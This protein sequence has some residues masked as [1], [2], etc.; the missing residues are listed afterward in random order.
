[1]PV[2]GPPGPKKRRVNGPGVSLPSGLAAANA[3]LP[4]VCGALVSCNIA[5]RTCH[6]PGFTS[7]LTGVGGFLGYLA[8]AVAMYLADRVGLS[9]LCGATNWILWTASLAALI[10]LGIHAGKQGAPA[11]RPPATVLL[12]LAPIA[13][14]LLWGW[15]VLWIPAQGWDVLGTRTEGF[16]SWAWT[17]QQFIEHAGTDAA[18]AFAYEHRHPITLKLVLAWSGWSGSAG[19]LG[20]GSMMPWLTFGISLLLVTGGFSWWATRS[21]GVTV[22]SCLVLT[23]IPLIENHVLIGGYSELPIALA[24]LSSAVFFVLG[25]STASRRWLGAGIVLALLP[26]ALKNTGI[27]YT[28]MPII[29]LAVTLTVRRSPFLGLALLAGLAVAAA[30]L[31]MNGFSTQF[32]GQRLEFDPELQRLIFAGKVLF[33]D[34]PP[35][36]EL[37]E[38]QYRAFLTNQSFSLSTAIVLLAFA[39]VLT[40]RGEQPG[41]PGLALLL[42][43]FTFCVLTLVAVQFSDYGFQYARPDSDTGLSRFSVPAFVLVPAMTAYLLAVLDGRWRKSLAPAGQALASASPLSTAAS[44]KPRE[45]ES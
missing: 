9:I 19:A 33:L 23:S 40:H 26:V 28:L 17:A 3:A 16:H 43:T 24:M 6:V 2:A 8:I 42:L 21:H 5:L 13:V 41:T 27:V 1:M 20:L 7:V 22:V 37:W 10:G 35:M 4:W 36:A 39:T 45:G 34:V 18:D 12:Y 14:V 15:Q 25:V 44:T 11:S 29:A 31:L 38:N 32:L 30:L